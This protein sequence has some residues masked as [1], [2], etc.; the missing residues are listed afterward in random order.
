[1]IVKVR[2]V[3]PR[4]WN[5]KCEGPEAAACLTHCRGRKEGVAGVRR[6]KERVLQDEAG[7]LGG[8][9]IT[10]RFVSHRQKFGFYFTWDGKPSWV[11]AGD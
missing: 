2:E 11:S 3:H 1:M 5:G 6:A 4:Q 8:I 9:Q 10:K 7:V